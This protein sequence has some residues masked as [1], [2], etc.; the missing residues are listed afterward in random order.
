VGVRWGVHGRRVQRQVLWRGG[1]V[2]LLVVVSHS[3][4]WPNLEYAT[5]EVILALSTWL[6]VS[7]QRVSFD[8]IQLA[9]ENYQ[10]AVSC[11][12]VDVIMGSIALVWHQQVSI[13]GNCIRLTFWAGVLFAF[14][15]F[16][17]EVAVLVHLWGVGW[18]WVDGIVG[19]VGYFLVWL[20][21]WELRSWSVFA[22]GGLA[23][24]NA[25]G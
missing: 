18:Y 9:A 22:D 8:T 13:A 16:R 7:G 17:L 1:L 24:G 19:G 15:A 3:L 12:F 11:T 10:F 2:I 25:V 23:V 21:I 5:S 6:G 4:E 14:N 20:A